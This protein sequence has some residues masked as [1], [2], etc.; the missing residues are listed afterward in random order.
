MGGRSQRT[1][2]MK[3]TQSFSSGRGPSYNPVTEEGVMVG[4]VG[5]WGRPEVRGHHP[6]EGTCGLRQELK[7]SSVLEGEGHSGERAASAR[8]STLDHTLGSLGELLKSLSGTST[9]DF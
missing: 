7:S 3:K 2:I 4:A 9:N 8:F 5:A 6:E 1:T